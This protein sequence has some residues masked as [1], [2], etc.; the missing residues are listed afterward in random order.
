MG[1]GRIL[2]VLEKQPR[3]RAGQAC[4]QRARNNRTSAEPDDLVPAFR[5]HGGKAADHDPQA[6]EVREPAKRIRHDQAASV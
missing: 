3:D 4:R 1:L 2:C 5:T 6:G